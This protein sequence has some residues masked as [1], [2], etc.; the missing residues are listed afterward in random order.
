MVFQ[1]I[2]MHLAHDTDDF[3]E[4]APQP[5]TPADRILVGPILPR[6]CFVDQD[7]YRGVANFAI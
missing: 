5:H 1:T 2:V 3:P 7:Y 4:L 6:Q